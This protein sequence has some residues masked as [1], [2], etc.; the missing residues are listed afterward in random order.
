MAKITKKGQKNEKVKKGR[1]HRKN[2]YIGKNA[3]RNTPIKPSC[4]RAQRT[5]PKQQKS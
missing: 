2:T 3:K 1:K 4:N 5:P